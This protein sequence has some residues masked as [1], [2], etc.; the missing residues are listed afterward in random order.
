MCMTTGIDCLTCS[1]RHRRE[2]PSY[3]IL[4]DAIKNF[5][6]E[7]QTKDSKQISKINLRLQGYF[8]IDNITAV[9]LQQEN[10]NKF[11]FIGKSAITGYCEQS[12]ILLY[13][14]ILAFLGGDLFSAVDD[15]R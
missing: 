7:K 10:E 9:H 6:E 14:I 8:M 13:C 5:L 3:S 2:I 11:K 4:Q 15:N 1:E 12:T